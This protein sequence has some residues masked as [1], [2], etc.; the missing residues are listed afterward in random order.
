MSTADITKPCPAAALTRVRS[1]LEPHTNLVD[2]LLDDPQVI[3][4][5]HGIYVTD[6]VG[7][8]YIEGVAGLWCTTLGFSEERLVDA[9]VRQLRQ[10]P[11]Y[12]S[13]NHRTHDVAIELADK[14]VSIAPVPMTQAFFASSGSEANET[15]VKLVW[16][17]NNAVGRPS[18][19]KILAHDRGYHG[20]TLAAGSLTGLPHIHRG[21]DL[22]L[23]V[24]RHVRS[25]YHY[26][27]AH[28]DESE[29]SFVR[30][31]ADELDAVI[32]AEGS[33][34]VA[35]FI[36]E[37]VLGAGGVIVPPAGY[38]PA[39]QE[40]LRR[41]DVLLIADE[42]ITAFG[43][44]GAMF[45]SSSFGL[46][47]DIITMAKGLSSAYLPI[48]AVLV[49]E[50]ISAALLEGSGRFGAFGHGFTYSGHPVTAA[51]ALEAIRIYEER[52]IPGH[53]RAMASPFAAALREL[54][55]HPLVGEVRHCGLMAGIELV[56]SSTTGRPFDPAV[57]I[58]ARLTECAQ[59]HGLI[60]R[61]MGDTVALAPPLVITELEIGELM[62]RLRFALDELTCRLDV[63]GRHRT[64]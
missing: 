31:L 52:D 51:V 54:E 14:L 42:V 62:R 45:G 11:F 19:K 7:N 61:A 2:G 29:Q 58:G 50:R 43:R 20:V 5:G 55:G 10:L 15:A 21:F 53:V 3:T 49:G 12:G 47:P 56:A 33:E 23:P 39:V 22:P 8:E 26:R 37:P 32:E 40:V 18:K 63:S 34:T 60:V 30:R 4:S 57:R 25:P 59:G 48:S 17:C 38:F 16:Y 41:H 6:D 46:E 36:A 24:V 35:A 28:P 1:M 27:E 64:T 9:A 44:T 13:F